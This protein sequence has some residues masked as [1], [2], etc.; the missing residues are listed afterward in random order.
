[1]A[2][3]TN[4][5]SSTAEGLSP[6]QQLLAKHKA[7]EAHTVQVED[8]VDEDDIQHPPP[9]A[10]HAPT[11]EPNAVAGAAAP[12]SEVAKGKQK[13]V[14]PQEQP[15]QQSAP[16]L[17]T[18]S[19]E[20]FP[21]L[22]PP[23]GRA[24]PPVAQV[25]GKK[26]AIVSLNGNKA[27]VNGKTPSST[28]SSRPGTPAS[29]VNGSAGQ[30]GVAL[31]GRHVE[32]IT[33][34]PRQLK[35][36][37]DMRKPIPQLLQE[38]NKKSKAKV[39]IREGMGG[40]RVLEGTGPVDA[41]RE[42]LREIA[43]Q[44][45][46]KQA[47][48]V[49]VPA[50][51]RAQIIGRGGA[52][53]Q[54]MSK[55]TG[56][57]IQVPKQEQL[58]A[59]VEDDDDATIDVTIEGDPVA[60]EL[61]RR[62]IEQIVNEKT[63]SV[64]YRL[65]DIP[66]EFYPF[67]AGPRNAGLSRFANSGDVRVN[68]PHY[69][70]WRDNA[71]A[72]PAARGA[73]AAFTPQSSLPIHISGDRLAAQQARDQI[74]REVEALRRQLTTEEMPVERG[75]HQF[76]LG[77]EGDALHDFMEETGCSIIMPPSDEDSEYLYVIG[78]ADRIQGGVD[79]VM[80]LASSMALTN[81][82]VAR[83]HANA[84]RGGFTHAR[85]LTRYLQQRQAVADLEKRHNARIVLPSGQSSAPWEVYSREGKDGMRAR[86]EIMDLIKAHPPSRVHP[87]DVH[88][89][90]HQQLQEREAAK[91]R[92][93]HGVHLVFPDGPDGDPV[94]L[95]Y[96]KPGSPSGY[97]FPRQQ[98]TAAEIQEHQ[99][100]IELAR[101]YLEELIRA[102]EEIVSRD[103]EAE[104]K[105]HPKVQ[106]FVN[107][108][109]QGLPQNQYPVQLLF[110]QPARPQLQRTPT[111]SFVLR[112]PSSAVDDMN[113]KI[114]AF[115]EQAEKDELERSYTT[116]FEFPQK[117]A[118]LLIGRRGDNINKLREQFDVDIQVQDGKVELKG[119]QAKCAACKNHILSQAKKWEDEATH[120][121]TVKPEYHRDLIGQ[122]G[123]QVNRLQERYNVRINFPRTSAAGD[124]DAATESSVKNVRQQA[125]DQVVIRGP[126]KGVN[127][128]KS[129]LLDLL[130]YLMDNS[131]V[132]T[133]SVA[134]SQIPQLI[135]SGGRE[136]DALRA[137]TGC[138]I[139]V[140]PAKDADASG[141]VE[142]RIKGNKKKVEETK[143]IIQDRSKEFDNNVTRTIEVDKKHHRA[144]IGAGG[145]FRSAHSTLN[146]TNKYT[147]ANIH[148]IVSS[149]GG[150]EDARAAA[151]MVKFPPAGTDSNTIRVEGPQAIVDKIIAAIES[152]VRQKEGE[153]SESMEVPP[154]QHRL[155]IG[156]GGETR[157]SIESKFNVSVDIPRQGTT[158]PARSMIKVTGSSEGVPQAQEHIFKLLKEQEGETI[159]VPR[160]YHHAITEDGRIFRR[161]RDEHRV[162]VDHGGVELPPRPSST[163]GAK[164]RVNG[165]SA[166]PLITDDAP[167]A[168]DA[169]SWEVVDAAGAEGQDDG[170]VPWILR[171]P[172]SN[173]A[174]A[175]AHIE[176]ALRKAQ[177]PSATGFLI[178]PDPKVYR[179]VI[180][181]KGATINDIRERTGCKINVPKQGEK[182]AEEGIEIIGSKEG[183]EQARDLILEAVKNG[184]QGS[185]G[186][187]R[188]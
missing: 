140:P 163:R 159:Q 100:A 157:R 184:G 101:K 18:D 158:G 151:R 134:Q 30:P 34:T 186:A 62:E 82:D 90:F 75:K 117:F 61:A 48:T 84:P 107:Q 54:A 161:L 22:G 67:L 182:D 39:T 24:P 108:E 141:R 153:V 6:A 96:E 29:T 21:A 102:H 47:V 2:A 175:R 187:R 98:P 122:K 99:Q 43:T 16:R 19:E 120:T 145:G 132:A 128:A 20:A 76:I 53:I 38:I 28:T 131:Y 144:I 31:P 112:G 41:V 17:N 14:E 89:F 165:S 52:T 176:A 57:K 11:N 27:S 180:G 97:E 58:A 127:E 87:M 156:R 164:R 169:H 116:N 130:N 81:V 71:P 33:F 91:I 149:A 146:N 136:M 188:G 135:G 45:G 183:V 32:R 129:E 103:I 8:V 66:P 86:Q 44:I 69:H 119:P 118:N 80:D 93:E 166:M 4:G 88:P 123:S 171:G 113:A 104:A 83:Q 172:P 150:P 155:L 12:M 85:N 111:G 23:K 63:G 59:P 42:A 77:D 114:L 35:D 5:G 7:D 74:Q 138:Q 160:K 109:Q 133:V 56:A 177:T 36:P 170:H 94:L 1:M 9:S 13:A 25:W 49:A 105:F 15:K 50:S 115:L 124:D 40:V 79:K 78:P 65:R 68:I 162:S 126:S 139:D 37:K 51:V 154:E 3:A 106:R 26:P 173:V 70:T 46:A 143:K 60:A 185:G 92:R 137:Q 167:S 178:L 152:H 10:T 121:I 147:G 142:I 72:Q 174:K 95:V 55:R 181:P 110:G 179:Y 73:P 148:R 168:Q 125:P 64:N